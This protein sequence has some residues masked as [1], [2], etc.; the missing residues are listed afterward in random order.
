MS[1]GQTGAF[2]FASFSEK[3]DFLRVGVVSVIFINMSI[4]FYYRRC[5]N[6]K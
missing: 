5:K 3:E 4:Y 6:A 2:V 1:E